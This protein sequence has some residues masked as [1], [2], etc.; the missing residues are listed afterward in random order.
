LLVEKQVA[1]GSSDVLIDIRDLHVHFKASYAATGVPG[2]S[3]EKVVRAVDGITLPIKRGEI[4]SLVGE[5]GSGKTTLG[6]TIVGL[7]KPTSGTI[8]LEGKEI[9]FGK[10]KALRNLWKTTQMIFQDPYSTFNPLSTVV[11]ALSI[12]VKKFQLAKNETE[13][14][15]MI[16]ETL[17]DVG[18][19]F[20]DIEGKY[21]N[22]LSGGQRQRA[23]IARALIVQPEII[24]ADEPVSMLD[25][26]LRA[27]ILEL[28]KKLNQKSNLTV[29][30]I[31]HDLAVAQYIGDRIA[32]MYRG[33]I[34]ELAE[35]NEL[36]RKPAHPYTELLLRS[37]PRLKGK[38]GWSETQ[39]MTFRSVDQIKFKG[40]AFYPRCPLGFD[41][42]VIEEPPLVEISDGHLA[43]CHLRSARV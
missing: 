28:L 29:V 9:N 16:Q 18:L 10:R 6:R 8:I 24:V 39:E 27:G 33:K 25:V 21:P 34:V 4:I 32:V 17:Y 35:A 36:I 15:K 12:P 14:R 23:S 43:S 1:V 37:A 30:F 41:R 5:S 20:G 22:E 40:C 13:T 26:S 2:L 42:C 19:E 7:S 11:D 31:A 38:Q 3:S